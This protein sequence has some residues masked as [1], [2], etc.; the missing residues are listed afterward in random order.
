M[1]GGREDERLG[2]SYLSFHKDDDLVERAR[3]AS[4]SGEVRRDRTKEGIYR[5]LLTLSTR[6][7][8]SL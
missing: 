4:G 2:V 5:S 8:S 1:V 6:Y 3:A 7:R